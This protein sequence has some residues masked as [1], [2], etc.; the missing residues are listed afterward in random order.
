MQEEIFGPILPLLTYE[1]LEECIRF[2]RSRPK[3]LALYLF[4]ESRAVEEKILD[5]CSFGGGCVN[6]T[7]IHLANPLMGF[8]GVGAS[9][10]GSYHGKLSFDTFTHYRSIVRKST[11]INMP[12]RY[13]PYTEKKFRMLKKLL[14]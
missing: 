9:G 7:I 5:T 8:G 12:V 2:I 13:H 14:K 10:M 3:P 1:N 6:D 11:W 4:T